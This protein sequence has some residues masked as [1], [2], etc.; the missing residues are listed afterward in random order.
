MIGLT[1]VKAEVR[2][3]IDVLAAERERERFGHRGGAGQGSVGDSRWNASGGEPPSL[4][5]VFLGNPGTGKATV[6]RLM[7]EIMRPFA[8]GSRFLVAATP[9]LRLRYAVGVPSMVRQGCPYGPMHPWCRG[10]RPARPTP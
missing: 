3:L 8:V 2:K 5:C 10:C 4:H 7:G 6:A 1:A 9:P